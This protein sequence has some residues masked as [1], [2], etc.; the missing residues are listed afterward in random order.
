VKRRILLLAILLPIL[1]VTAACSQDVGPPRII[2]VAIAAD[3][4]QLP[5]AAGRDR[6]NRFALDSY[7]RVGRLHTLTLCGDFQQLVQVQHWGI[8]LEMERR[9]PAARPRRHG[10]SMFQWRSTEGAAL[11]GRNFDHKTSEMVA[12]WC[13]PDSGYASLGFIPLNQ[14]GFTP[15]NPFDPENPQHRS[16][17]LLGPVNTIEGL[18]EKGVTVTLASLEAQPTVPDPDKQPRFLI[19]LVREILD[20]AASLDEAVAI[21]EKYNVFD[22]GKNLITHHIF[23]ADAD[24]GSAVLEWQDGRMKVLRS[25]PQAQVCTNRPVAGRSDESLRRDCRR[26]RVLAEALDGAGPHFGW[27]QG[28]SALEQAAQHNVLFVINGQ[29]WRVSTQWSAVF[30]LEAGQ[31]FLSLDRDYGT[32]YRLEVPRRPGA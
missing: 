17:L 3:P 16:M 10:C 7:R 4:A 28:M 32:V 13:Y 6:Q 31:V 26:Y 22:N 20:H 2:D 24:H 9:E 21:A 8:M 30:D 29:R 5:A 25:G 19:H 11:V 15:E 1:A 14:W 12:A 27:Q 23:V 18:N